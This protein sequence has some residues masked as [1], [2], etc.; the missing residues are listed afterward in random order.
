M[1]ILVLAG[2]LC[3]KINFR[4]IAHQTRQSSIAT[5]SLRSALG[6][7]RRSSP[8]VVRWLSFG[9]SLFSQQP[10]PKHNRLDHLFENFGKT[11]KFG[12]GFSQNSQNSQNSQLSQFSQFSQ[13]T[14]SPLQ[15]TIGPASIDA[16]PDCSKLVRNYRVTT[17]I[18]RTKRAFFLAAPP[19]VVFPKRT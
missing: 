9:G 17:L 15:K 6:C 8:A 16:E 13:N 18:P 3:L 4:H 7:C 2:R 10:T 14:Q 5:T 1:Q 12:R 11:G 19:C